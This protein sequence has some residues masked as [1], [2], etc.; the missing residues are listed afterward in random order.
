[1]PRA[2]DYVR[3]DTTEG[4]SPEV[5]QQVIREHFGSRLK[6]KGFSWGGF[7]EDVPTSGG[8]PLCSRPQGLILDSKLERSDVVVFT[9]LDRGFCSLRDAADVVERWL[10]RGIHL[11]IVHRSIDTSTPMGQLFVNLLPRFADLRPSWLSERMA[12]SLAYRRSRGRPP[13]GS[14]PC[15]FKIAGPRGK[16]RFIPDPITRRID[17]TRD[18][19]TLAGHKDAS[20]GG[21]EWAS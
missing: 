21:Q 20:R 7:F 1:M 10:A 13:G 2:Y 15:G 14:P 3:A 18:G 8:L 6:D 19:E 11:H 4:D 12:E 17:R 9:M 16:R 5:Q